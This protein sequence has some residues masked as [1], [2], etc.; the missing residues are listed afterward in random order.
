MGGDVIIITTEN[1]VKAS[2]WKS[3]DCQIEPHP[4]LEGCAFVV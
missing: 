1:M 3:F 2:G 4:A